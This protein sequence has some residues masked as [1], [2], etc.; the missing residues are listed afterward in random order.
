MRGLW[1]VGVAAVVAAVVVSGAA[2]GSSSA[3]RCSLW[4]APSGADTSPGTQAAPFRT[5]TRLAGALT[6]G[7]VGCLPSGASFA[8]REL[9]TAVGTRADRITIT[10]APG[11]ARAILADG[12]ETT[13][14]TRFLTL[15]NLTIGALENSAS[16]DV[17]GT[18]ILR[19]Y[20][21]ALTR[22]D[23]GPGTSCSSTLAPP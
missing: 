6:P 12:I 1:I 13:Q 4:A 21:T 7:Q 16:K 9:I 18:V 2:G 10:T 8:A 20:S 15:T 3:A 11:G 14:A 23:V 19:G 22:S 5:L 17:P